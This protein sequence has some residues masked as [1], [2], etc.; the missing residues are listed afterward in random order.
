MARLKP[1]HYHAL[2]DILIT[3]LGEDAVSELTDENIEHFGD[4]LLA[5]GEIY[6]F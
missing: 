5:C 2:K 3:E 1:E 6:P 4:F